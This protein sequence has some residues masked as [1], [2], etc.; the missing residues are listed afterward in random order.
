VTDE[1][2]VPV[3]PGGVG[4][5]VLTELFPFV[6]M[7]PLI[8]YRT[9]DIVLL[10]NDENDDIQFEWLGRR[11]NCVSAYINGVQT[12]LLG[13]RPIADWLSLQP[14]V[15]RQEHRPWL[16]SVKSTDLG[17]PCVILHSEPAAAAVRIHIGLRINPWWVKDLVQSLVQEMWN[18][19]RSM[20]TV[21]PENVRVQLC[22]RHFSRPTE[23]FVVE[24]D[25]DLRFP[26]EVLSAP[27]PHML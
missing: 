14:L 24:D 23:L 9:G 12:W 20:V 22:F 16:S 10:I 8:R 4:E 11:G 27:P 18:A 2:G 3:P 15:A 19:L 13:Y 6:Q 17:P 26:V 7:Q 21:P 25:H 1:Q 5:L